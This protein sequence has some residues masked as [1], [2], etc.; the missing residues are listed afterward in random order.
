MCLPPLFWP[1]KTG[2]VRY[3]GRG[4]RLIRNRENVSVIRTR[5]AETESNCLSWKKAELCRGLNYRKASGASENKN[6]LPRINGLTVDRW[7]LPK[8]TL[9]WRFTDTLFSERQRAAKTWYPVVSG[10]TDGTVARPSKPQEQLSHGSRAIELYKGIFT[11][12]I[13]TVAYVINRYKSWRSSR[14]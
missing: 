5:S 11:R 6:R 13:T 14:K 7:L 9:R 8:G 1:L 3:P 12:F 10:H 4:N 2:E